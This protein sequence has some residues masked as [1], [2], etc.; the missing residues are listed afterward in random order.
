M[1]WTGCRYPWRVLAFAVA[2]ETL[3]RLGGPAAAITVNETTADSNSTTVVNQ[4]PK[5]SL[6][7]GAASRLRGLDDL[8]PSTRR[9][10]LHIADP[11]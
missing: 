10:G 9:D 5:P 6:P 1:S 8:S 2:V 11:E 4:L 3:S 7:A